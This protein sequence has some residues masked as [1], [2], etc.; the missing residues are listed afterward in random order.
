MAQQKS[1]KKDKVGGGQLHM[2]LPP[3]LDKALRKVAEVE[4]RTM[5]NLAQVLLYEAL[6]ARGVKL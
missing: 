2:K 1:T 5:H 6:K 3:D 4:R